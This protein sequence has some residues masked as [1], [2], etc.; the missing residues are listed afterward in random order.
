VLRDG[1]RLRVGRAY[2]EMVYTRL[3]GEGAQH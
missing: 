3:K 1:R 2:R